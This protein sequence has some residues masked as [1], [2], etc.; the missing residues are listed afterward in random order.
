MYGDSA[1]YTLVW[2]LAIVISL[3]IV[4]FVFIPNNDAKRKER[5]EKLRKLRSSYSAE[6]EE[7]YE[8]TLSDTAVVK[9]RVEVRNS[10]EPKQ[11][12]LTL[13]YPEWE[14]SKKDGTR[15]FRRKDNYIL[16]NISDLEI[17]SWVVE[18][19]NPFSM[20]CLVMD[21]RE[22]GHE[23]KYCREE[24]EKHDTVKEK[25]LGIR[26]SQ[27]IVSIVSEFKDNPADFENYCADLLRMAGWEVEVTPPTRDGGFDL[28]LID[29]EGVVF[30][31]ECKC[32]APSSRVGRPVIQ[33]L[34]GANVLENADGL[35]VI[36]TS[37]FT[38]EARG[39]ADKTG[40]I[41][42]DGGD[43]LDLQKEALSQRREEPLKKDYHT[44][45][46]IDILNNIPGDIR[47]LYGES[48]RRMTERLKTHTLSKVGK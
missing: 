25:A 21:L 16:D 27:S 33:K 9:K 18:D 46:A 8:V 15:D 45:T 30:L 12:I 42:L 1:T 39:Y 29:K 41:L 47:Q 32:Y 38:K 5:S 4:C 3:M 48:C 11:G 2:M 22:N 23:V 13:D 43:L 6:F 19:E 26:K 40:V 34:Q 31:A 35:L 17:D 10:P 28:K 7:Q 44:L 24:Q 36:T 14:F 20:Y 37:N